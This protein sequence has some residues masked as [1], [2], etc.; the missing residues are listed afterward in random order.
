MSLASGVVSLATRVGVE[1]KT[2]FRATW[3]ADPGQPGF[4]M[5]HFINY[6]TTGGSSPLMEFWYQFGGGS[7]ASFWLNENGNPRAA[8]SKASDAAMK[9]VGWGT[10]QTNATFMIE[11]RSGAGTGGR[12]S[13]WGISGQGKPLLGPNEVPGENMVVLE[14]TDTA[15]P[16]GTPVGTVLMKKRT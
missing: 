13:S 8:M 15:P 11:Q 16:T 7:L 3:V 6:S 5:Q 14:S 4:L 10:G 2:R 12:S 9:L 1:F